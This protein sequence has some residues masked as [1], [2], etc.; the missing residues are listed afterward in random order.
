MR[1]MDVGVLRAHFKHHIWLETSTYF[2][3]WS[4]R[5]LNNCAYFV[6]IANVSHSHAYNT[7]TIALPL[8]S[9]ICYY[10]QVNISICKYTLNI[11]NGIFSI[12][13][14]LIW[15][16]IFCFIWQSRCYLHNKNFNALSNTQRMMIYWYFF[17][18][19]IGIDSLAQYFAPVK[20]IDLFHCCLVPPLGFFPFNINRMKFM[21]PISSIPVKA[22]RIYSNA[23]VLLVF[24]DGVHCSLYA[25]HYPLFYH[26]LLPFFDWIFINK[27][28]FTVFR[29]EFYYML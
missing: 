3:Y 7:Y 8:R 14:L 12:Q 13:Y 23:V 19:L 17:S 28:R 6:S 15:L 26:P 2:Y 29:F 21:D 27:N 1:L 25:L 10:G 24:F 16:P 4:I 20:N 9:T 22:F 5:L 18:G 11:W